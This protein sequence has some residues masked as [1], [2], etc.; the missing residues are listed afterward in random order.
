VKIAQKIRFPIA[1]KLVTLT[2]TLLLIASALI[3]FS[4]TNLLEK[5]SDR[6]EKQTNQDLAKMIRDQINV[7][8]DKY[9]D[10]T[11]LV[12]AL[13]NQTYE[14]DK[15]KNDTLK[16]SFEQDPDFVGIVIYKLEDG[17]QTLSVKL[18][19]K[20]YLQKYN[21]PS[22]YLEKLQAE[23]PFP[24][25]SVFSGNIEV[26]NA[27][28]PNGAPLIALGIPFKDSET[29]LISTVAISYMRLNGVQTL[30]SR[31]SDHTYYLVDKD[32][33]VLSHPNDKLVLE[34]CKFKL[35]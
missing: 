29:G 30:F 2:V 21:L 26:R 33:T 17:R 18:D 4:S 14:N 15:A 11:R 27:S 8:L 25:S 7:L 32:G 16:L 34:S 3:T 6:T 19:K 12:T 35:K 22:D 13:L 9:R 10:K 5:T 23:K 24:V 28:L 31:I 20:D 1:I